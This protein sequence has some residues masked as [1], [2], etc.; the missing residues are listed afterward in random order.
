MEGSYPIDAVLPWVDGDD[1]VLNARRASYMD[2]GQA[3]D[4]DIAGATRYKG[5]GEIRY[6]IASILRYAPFVRKIFIVTDGQDPGIEHEKVQVVDHRIIFRGHEEGL[7]Y[8][9]SNSIDTFI[10]NIPEL[11][12]HFI[13]F[14]DDVFLTAPT[15]PEDFFRD[16]QPVA[17]GKWYP[18]FAAKAL[19]TLKR[20]VSGGREAAGFKDFMLNGLALCGGGCRFVLIGHTPHALL[21]SWY[22]DFLASN[23]R[24]VELNLKDRFR[25]ADQWS[26]FEPFYLDMARRRRLILIPDKKVSL[27]LKPRPAKDYFDRKIALFDSRPDAIFLC[28]NSLD[29]AD[30]ADK[31]KFTAWLNRRIGL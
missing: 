21:K 7:P 12:E 14:N 18:T 22:A 15:R 25:S 6:C 31:E 26:V 30:E 9:N 29:K 19:R 20:L 27:Y 16:G 1:P 3:A 28:A 2:A 4:D 5:I 11:S 13:Y 8:F 24:A 17:Y 10:W 23:P